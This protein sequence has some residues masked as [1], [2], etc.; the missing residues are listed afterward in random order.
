[1]LDCDDTPEAHEAYSHQFDEYLRQ[2]WKPVLEPRRYTCGWCGHAIATQYGL[3]KHEQWYEATILNPLGQPREFTRDI[4]VCVQCGGATTFVKDE[5]YPPPLLGEA[6]DARQKSAEV[7]LIVVLYDE[8]RH[9]L[10]QGATR[11]AVVMFRKLLM[12]IAVERGAAKG[13]KFVQYCEH[14]KTT[15]VVGTPMHGLLDRIKDGGNEE[16]HEI[17]RAP[18]EKGNRPLEP[19]HSIDQER[20]L[21]DLTMSLRALN[22]QISYGP[23][24]DRLNQFFIPAMEASI[25]YERAAGYFSSTTLAIAAKGVAQL[26]GMRFTKAARSGDVRVR[27]IILDGRLD[28]GTEGCAYNIVSADVT[29]PNNPSLVGGLYHNTYS[30]NRRTF[31]PG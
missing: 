23:N 9:A 14:L 20:V 13:L 26:I 15:N 11:G 8:A 29:D 16:N 28:P 1:M 10:C 19:R 5:Q 24:D 30:G 21:R 6:M 27:E 18:R 2:G 31:F 12:H 7:K 17:V 4:R 25:R 22:L 3:F